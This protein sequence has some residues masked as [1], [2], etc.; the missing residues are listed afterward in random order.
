MWKWFKNL[1]PK[2][3][4]QWWQSRHRISLHPYIEQKYGHP[5]TEVGDQPIGVNKQTSSI[6]ILPR[7]YPETGYDQ[8][9]QED[10]F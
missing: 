10:K 8:P 3:D 1:F 5:G 7:W 4:T 6:M 2:R 9:T